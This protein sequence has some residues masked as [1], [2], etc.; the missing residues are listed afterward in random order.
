MECPNCNRTYDEDFKFCPFCGEEK[1]EP[2]TCPDCGYES[3]EYSFCPNC[4]KKLLNKTKLNENKIRREEELK[5]EKELEEKNKKNEIYQLI[6]EIENNRN[7]VFMESRRS[8]SGDEIYFFI[9]NYNNFQTCKIY[10]YV[11]SY[12]KLMISHE[13]YL[14]DNIS[15]A[16]IDDEIRSNIYV[17]YDSIKERVYSDIDSRRLRNDDSYLDELDEMIEEEARE[18]RNEENICLDF[19]M[20]VNISIKKFNFRVNGKSYHVL[21]AY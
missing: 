9:S 15:E 16:W 4:G 13:Y 2:L 17:D 20:D 18:L 12:G 14:K 7:L 1:P 11:M 5:K 10:E 19:S 3:R 8:W 6:K 21:D